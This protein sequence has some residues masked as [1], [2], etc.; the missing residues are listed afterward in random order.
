M[1]HTE[2]L[3]I[4]DDYEM[5]DRID[6]E[7]VHIIDDQILSINGYVALPIEN[8]ATFYDLELDID[9][10]DEAGEDLG[11]VCFSKEV[12]VPTAFTDTQLIAY[13]N[14]VNFGDYLNGTAKIK[15]SY[16]VLKEDKYELYKLQYYNTAPV[17]GNFSHEP[18]TIIPHKITVDKLEAIKLQL[19]T[20][21][22]KESI[23]RAILQPYGFE[24]FLKKYH[25]LELLFD[26]DF[27][28]GIKEL[29]G[30][31]LKGIGKLVQDFNK[32]EE[33]AR[34]RQVIYKR[35]ANINLNKLV[36]LLNKITLEKDL[37]VEI[38]FEYGK[39]NSNP[40]PNAETKSSLER[41]NEMIQNDSP[42]EY[43]IVNRVMGS[44]NNPNKHKKFLIDVSTY[45]I[46][47]VRCS[48]AHS[49]I[50][51][52]ILKTDDEK[53]VVQIIEPLLEFLIAEC[54]TDR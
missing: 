23:N 6:E 19:P 25:M 49:K 50:G 24:R 21:Y 40:F 1:N 47:R 27:V 48:I 9:I 5:D 18:N 14:D 16:V 44:I 8:L 31:N 32:R 34:L 22:H 53:F 39:E 15:K 35:S 20:A 37:A 2:V 54:F 41:F 26:L 3:K 43:E 28:E 12:E 13:I 4:F 51:E 29:D 42:F 7:S 45:W 36:S 17:W 38:F 10:I 52:Y 30:D 33:I 11:V 46:Y